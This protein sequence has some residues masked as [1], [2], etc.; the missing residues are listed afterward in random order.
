MDSKEFEESV[1]RTWKSF[2][3]TQVDGSDIELL[4]GALLLTG[5]AGEFADA[6]KK[7]L[8]YGQE[9]DIVNMIE[10]L[11]DILYGVAAMAEVLGVTL[12][13]VMANNKSKLEQRYPNGYS[14]ADSKNRF[15]KM[16]DNYI[17]TGYK[18][19]E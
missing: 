4:H 18:V 10:E 8:I 19:G 11:G 13:Y 12:D 17:Q 14:D 7:Y 16:I 15:D 6:V 3:T 5:E 1:Q 9:P 2:E